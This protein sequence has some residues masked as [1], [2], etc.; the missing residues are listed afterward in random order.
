MKKYVGTKII[1]AE[2]C[3]YYDYYIEKYK[4]QPDTSKEDLPGYRVIYPPDNY[5]SWS[6]KE[7]FE[8]AY[9]DFENLTFDRAFYMLMN[10]YKVY[11]KCD[12]WTDCY[13][14][15]NEGILI[16][17][18]QNIQVHYRPNEKDMFANDWSVL[19]G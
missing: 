12:Q 10:G 6:P 18:L 16:K 7:V 15:Y 9:F 1:E 19:D 14:Y 11:R 8:E 13:L 3:N 17:M 5:I 2:P 4:S